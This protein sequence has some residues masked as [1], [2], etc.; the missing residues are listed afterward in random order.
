MYSQTHQQG[1]HGR[2]NGG[3]GRGMNM[4]H[5]FQPYQATHQQHA[6]HQASL[7]QDH[8]AHATNGG[9]LAHHANYSGVM[10]NATPFTP[11][12][13]QNGHTGVTR[14]GQAQSITEHWAKQ[15]EMHKEAEKAHAQM[16][17]GAPHHY[18]RTKA[19]DNRGLTPTAAP[20]QSNDE[21]GEENK[22]LGRMSSSRMAVRQDWYNLDMSGQGLRMLA[23]PVFKYAFLKEL[24]IAS[25]K[26]TEIPEA[27]GELRNLQY[28]DA[29]NN[30]LISLPNQLAM[31]VDLKTLLVFDNQIQTLPERLGALYKLEMLGI[32]GNPLD[33]EMK[34]ILME[35][36]TEALITQLRETA[37]IPRSPEPREILNLLDTEPPPNQERFKVFTYNILSDTACTK[38]LYGYSPARVLG[39][40]YRREEILKAIIMQNADFVCLQEVDFDAKEYLSMELAYHGYKGV[41]WPRTRSKTMM[42]KDAKRVDGCATF[43]KHGKYILIDKQLIDFANI[44][45]NRP[46]MKNQ[47]DIFNRVMPRDHIGV[48]TFFENKLTGTRLLLANTHIFWDPRYADVKIIQAAILLDTLNKFAEKYAAWPPLK[49]KKAIVARDQ[50][51]KEGEEEEEVPVEDLAVQPSKEYMSKTQ[52]PLIICADQNS[53][54]DS[55]VF[56]LLAKGML[57]PDHHELEGRKYGNFTKHGI[58]HPFSLKSAYTNLDKT[59]EAVPFTNYVPQYNG[60]IDHIW[61]S[62]NALENTALLGKVDP[63]YMKSVPGFPNAHF[64]SDHLPLMAEFAVKNTKAKAKIVEPDFGPSSRGRR[65]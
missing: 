8:A 65:N 45:I 9:V 55:G 37:T 6:Q 21:E 44:A 41:Y 51:N 60:V 57:A 26:L 54:I 62:T 40:E 42:E 20:D 14:G 34:Q 49:D 47:H 61:Y 52:L 33:A 63:E 46:D 31:C 17:E 48:A 15:L 27:I 24:Y 43:Y 3:P 28:L 12:N 16:L 19:A 18:A 30:A 1:Q 32:E 10:A 25:N 4:I 53:T 29:S 5:N 50:A 58:E 22:D 36:G 64:P 7:Q 11:N 56:E 38:K 59:T 39:W 23:S 35:E 13:L 2:V